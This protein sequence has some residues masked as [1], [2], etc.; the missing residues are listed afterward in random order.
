VKLLAKLYCYAVILFIGLCVRYAKR[1]GRVVHYTHKG[2]LYMTRYALWG[3]LTGDGQAGFRARLPNLYLHQMHAPD[4]D[5][6]LHDHPWPWALSWVMLGGYCEER[7]KGRQ[8]NDLARY[9]GPVSS[10][11]GY[12]N[13]KA[14]RWLQAPAVNVLRGST[15]HRLA[16]LA[17]EPTFTLFLAGSRAGKKPWGYIVYGRGYVSHQERHAEFDGQE[18]REPGPFKKATGKA[19][20]TLALYLG[21]ERRKR[22]RWFGLLNESDKVLRSRMAQVIR[23]VNRNSVE[24]FWSKGC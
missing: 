24:H 9:W 22:C 16:A 4:L 18:I 8:E 3:H 15:F 21:L 14:Q 19:L 20:D 7:F 1:R 12:E 23:D 17:D 11:Q 13:S 2:R 6:A 5:P 10:E